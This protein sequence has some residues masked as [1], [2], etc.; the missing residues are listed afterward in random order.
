MLIIVSQFKKE[1]AHCRVPKG[2]D[3][4][5]ELANWVRNQRLEQANLNKQGKKSRMTPERYELLNEL[6]FKWSSP[7]PAR[8][9]RS[10]KS[11]GKKASN[12]D[13]QKDVKPEEAAPT[14]EKAA[15]TEGEQQP[16]EAMAS[17]TGAVGT[18]A[19]E[20]ESGEAE[21]S[22]KADVGGAPIETEASEQIEV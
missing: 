1:H 15:E 2:Y 8:A 9:R 10:Y 4:D 11:A 17:A 14:E 20:G 18:L 6:G 5:W 3:K 21:E 22:A 13:E 12:G 19:T 16:E 7:T